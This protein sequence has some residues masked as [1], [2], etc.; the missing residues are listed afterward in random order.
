MPNPSHKIN[1]TRLPSIESTK[2]HQFQW[3][4]CLTAFTKLGTSTTG[5]VGICFGPF[6]H[7]QVT[8]PCFVRFQ[9]Q[10][11]PGILHLPIVHEHHHVNCATLT[12]P[13]RQIAT[14]RAP[15]NTPPAASNAL[16]SAAGCEEWS[17][18]GAIFKADT[19]SP[20]I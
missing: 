10:A 4:H 5:T 20:R 1:D 16:A 3:L 13:E 12:D 7:L 2:C 11:R 18:S 19:P 6:L 8:L 17:S 14:E 9:H 15:A